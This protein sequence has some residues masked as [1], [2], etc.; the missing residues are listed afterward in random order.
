MEI[1]I[2]SYDIVLF[3]IGRKLDPDYSYSP[4]SLT[5]FSFQKLSNFGKDIT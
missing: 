4:E 5:L 3:P 1:V 2:H